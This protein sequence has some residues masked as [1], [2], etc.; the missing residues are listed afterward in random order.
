M[1]T[2]NARP[3]HTRKAPP[4][5]FGA[6]PGNQ[7]SL[8]LEKANPGL[9]R[10]TPDSEALASSDDEVDGRQ[11]PTGAQSAGA[12][13][14]KRRTSWLSEI[15]SNQTR[16]PSVTLPGASNSPSGSHPVTP[17]G[18]QASR[19]H[20]G[21]PS[22]VATPSWTHS[23]QNFSWAGTMWNNE[24]RKEPSSRTQELIH[25]P[26]AVNSPTAAFLSDEFQSPP[27]SRGENT[28]SGINF[29]FP[30][31]PTPKTY[32]SS[33][34]SVG[35]QE[36]ELPQSGPGYPSLATVRGRPTSQFSALH[37]RGSRQGVLGELGHDSTILGRVREDEADSETMQPS[38]QQDS[39]SANQRIQS[40]E[41]ENA[42]LRQQAA[43]RQRTMSS[44]S[45]TSN[46]SNT[47]GHFTN[48]VLRGNVPSES[49]LA[50]EEGEDYRVM[51]KTADLPRAGRR[52]SEQLYALDSYSPI[53]TQP[54]GR[55]FETTRRA[56]WQ[57]SLGFGSIPEA[58]QS[59][60]HSFADVPTRHPSLGSLD[61]PT[62]IGEGQHGGNI[63]GNRGYPNYSEAA[64][65]ASPG[66]EPNRMVESVLSPAPPFPAHDSARGYSQ[67]T[68][69][70]HQGY[71]NQPLYI[72]T[73]KASRA[74]V[75]YVQ[76]GTGLD[77]KAG[78]LVI[79]EADRGTDL[80]TVARANLSYA[81]ARHMKE[82]YA[83][84]H[85][86]W[87]M[88]F[89]QQS[90]NGGPNPVNPNGLPAGGAGSAV[91]G[92]GPPGQHGLQEPATGELKPKLIKRLAQPHE[93]QTLKEKEGNEA[94]AKRVCQQK[95]AEH[96]LN[97]E[98]LDAEFQMDWKKL[99]FYYFADAYV[100]FNT[101][102][103]DLFKIYK[104]RIWMSA[105]NP[106]SFVTPTSSLNP[107]LATAYSPGAIG[108]RESPADRRR[109]FPNPA[110]SFSSTS[111]G[112]DAGPPV[113]NPLGR[114]N[115]YNPYDAF[116]YAMPQAGLGIP[117]Y[118][119][120]LGPAS[121]PF[122]TYPAGSY[123]VDSQS[124]YS[125]SQ[126]VLPRAGRTGQ[127]SEGDWTASFQGMSLGS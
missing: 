95:V 36:Q 88:M 62:G 19:M 25:S 5:G 105:I 86:K 22:L 76:E 112:A 14:P 52:H 20:T 66:E 65:D 104:T 85:Y 96:R 77:I 115:T 56:Q 46:F 55:P 33:S 11:I 4:P 126:P 18:D 84:D 3:S 42:R 39:Y 91:G 15:S 41:M 57:T 93:I 51:S 37:H 75:F 23:G 113:N 26:T 69:T 35:Q 61:E 111:F 21:S 12:T 60:R 17:S 9:R 10:A 67:H 81:Q 7:A 50:I 124:G 119:Q 116:G 13:K 44:T 102:V 29:P 92:M 127:N 6:L 90:R 73:F 45:A 53:S 87:L 114:P 27:G 99:T 118:P 98:I 100:N 94:K 121:D 103:T 38:N 43:L 110:S 58:P 78:D 109:G 63:A 125:G 28:K 106:A 31:N 49:D 1:T 30:L 34:Y 82:Q 24:T 107:H 68:G 101:L 108:G 70:P 32:R 47:A 89:S 80:G 8:L 83:E 72:V 48:P 54:E 2:V 123:L 97:M 74:E 40:L 79:V 64:I 122:S 71:R 117:P 16:K 120:N 59:R